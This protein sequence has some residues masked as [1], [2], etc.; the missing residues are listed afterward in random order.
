MLALVA[1][2]VV[3]ILRYI[4]YRVQR[5]IRRD[6]IIFIGRQYGFQF[7]DRLTLQDFAGYDFPPWETFP[8]WAP[9][10]FADEV[11]VWQEETDEVFSFNV[12][13]YLHGYGEHDRGPASLVSIIGMKVHDES[14]R[15]RMAQF[16]MGRKA[17]NGVVV[18]VRG[19]CVYAMIR[20]SARRSQEMSFRER[21]ACMRGMRKMRD[22]QFTEADALFETMWGDSLPPAIVMLPLIYFTCYYLARLLYTARRTDSG[23]GDCRSARDSLDIYSIKR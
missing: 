6:D 2:V 3:T 14:A 9:A 16:A 13:A 23:A 21:M 12:H 15:E 18:V 4:I 8:H 17:R 20:P 11:L 10:H 19:T 7:R 5:T 1:F 22:G